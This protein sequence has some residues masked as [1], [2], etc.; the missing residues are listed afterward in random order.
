MNLEI[1]NDF[2]ACWSEVIQRIRDG[3]EQRSVELKQLTRSGAG[4]VSGLGPTMAAIG[5][6]QPSLDAKVGD[7]R[8]GIGRRA[9]DLLNDS[10]VFHGFWKDFSDES[11]ATAVDAESFST[12][13]DNVRRLLQQI[14]KR[15]TAFGLATEGYCFH[16]FTE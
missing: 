14:A 15:S 11:W 13:C 8:L 3:E 10:S 4:R 9:Y 12:F 6:I 1:E 2:R 5:I 7:V 16:F